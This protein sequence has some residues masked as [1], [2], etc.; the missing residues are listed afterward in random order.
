ML[1]S[2]DGR[3]QLGSVKGG[4]EPLIQLPMTYAVD[5]TPDAQGAL[6]AGSFQ[7]SPGRETGVVLAL[8]ARGEI[9]TRWA[10]E[11]AVVTAVAA[12]PGGALG[13]RPRWD[14][15]VGSGWNK[16]PQGQRTPWV[17]ADSTP[18]RRPDRL[19]TGGP[20]RG[21]Q[22][23]PVLL[24]TRRRRLASR[25]ALGSL[26]V[27]LRRLAHR[28]GARRPDSQDDRFRPCNH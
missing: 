27:S 20:A 12:R 5:A 7:S 13:R 21:P 11:E 25:G 4:W 3:V 23:I 18:Q 15:A 19:H 8:D 24:P 26:A 17:Q 9:L 10:L 1:W 22:R 6:I 16:P 28:A 2:S 14:P